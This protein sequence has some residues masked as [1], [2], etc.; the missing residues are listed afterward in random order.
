MNRRKFLTITGAGIVVATSCYL[1]LSKFGHRILGDT[2]FTPQELAIIMDSTAIK[3]IGKEY[4]GERTNEADE[5]E[6][7]KL[8]SKSG[9]DSETS[10]DKLR[11]VVR[12]DFKTNET[13]IVDGWILSETEAR[14]SALFAIKNS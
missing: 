6:L 13:I 9:I 7:L 11:D 14:Q 2:L 1:Y 12:D 5:E 8:L 3:T 4:T 10:F